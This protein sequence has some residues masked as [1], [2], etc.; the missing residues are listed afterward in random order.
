MLVSI[1]VCLYYLYLYCGSWDLVTFMADPLGWR[2]TV[3]TEKSN[4][5]CSKQWPMEG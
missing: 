4:V 3:T 1:T 5:S 2:V